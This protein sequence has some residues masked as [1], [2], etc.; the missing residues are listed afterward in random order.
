[1]PT[2]ASG[3]SLVEP[4]SQHLAPLFFNRSMFVGAAGSNKEWSWGQ[5]SALQCFQAAVSRNL[6][7]HPCL[8]CLLFGIR[9]GR[10]SFIGR[11]EKYNG[12]I[13]WMGC[14]TSNCRKYGLCYKYSFYLVGHVLY[15][16]GRNL[17]WLFEYSHQHMI[18]HSM[19]TLQKVLGIS[20]IFHYSKC[21]HGVIYVRYY[22]KTGIY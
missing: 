7:Y 17:C 8:Y 19:Q 13:E 6:L 18:Q 5:S 21:E 9:R 22:S 11:K 14:T 15:P 10:V 12:V 20:V 4:W 2:P 1:M 16:F 3:C